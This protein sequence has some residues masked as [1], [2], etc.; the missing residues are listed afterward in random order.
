MKRNIILTKRG[1]EREAK[2]SG[3]G[4]ASGIGS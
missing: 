2:L 1:Y 4:T 3:D